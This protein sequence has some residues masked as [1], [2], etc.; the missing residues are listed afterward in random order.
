MLALPTG[1]ARPGGARRGR[2][3]LAIM[4]CACG[5]HENDQTGTGTGTGPIRECVQQPHRTARPVQRL[6]GGELAPRQLGSK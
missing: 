1:G 2:R 6:E 4:P 3:K 5:G